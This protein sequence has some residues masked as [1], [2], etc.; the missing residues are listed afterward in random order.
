MQR[1]L[2]KR[3]MT[4]L[5]NIFKYFTILFIGFIALSDA[6]CMQKDNTSCEDCVSDFNCYWCVDTHHCSDK[7]IGR[8]FLGKIRKDCGGG[9]WFS[10]KQCSI[11]GTYMSHIIFASVLV[12]VSIVATCIG[13]L[14]FWE[15]KRRNYDTIELT[16]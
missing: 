12:G 13:F 1:V 8:Y 11:N 5:T 6:T 3:R 15:Y 16:R 10:Y 4:S 7:T 2:L 14:C 9:E